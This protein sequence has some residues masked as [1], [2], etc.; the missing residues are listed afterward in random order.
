[1][2]QDGWW[3]GKWCLL[4]SL[5]TLTSCGV[6]VG[7]AILHPK[8]FEESLCAYVVATFI[9][10]WIIVL[11][12]VIS[13]WLWYRVPVPRYTYKLVTGTGD[14]ERTIRD[15]A[16]S[17]PGAVPAGERLSR[18][19]ASKE[20]SVSDESP[21]GRAVLRMAADGDHHTANTI[22]CRTHQSPD[23]ASTS[24][25]ETPIH[26]HPDCYYAA[27]QPTQAISVEEDDL[28]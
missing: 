10:G 9:G 22:T 1:M 17:T 20:N 21:L 6:D 12:A 18:R 24:H 4:C 14:A 7:R 16:A 13:Y 28:E 25:V 26:H 15:A 27:E 8:T 5:A 3:L 19:T 23:R 11:T 2:R